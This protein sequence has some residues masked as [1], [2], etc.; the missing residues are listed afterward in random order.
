MHSVAYR[1]QPGSL[2]E[3]CPIFY[4]KAANFGLHTDV[5]V[6]VCQQRL[7]A[8][9][10]LGYG[11]CQAPIVMDGVDANVP[12]A[13]D[14]RMEN[15]SQEFHNRRLHRVPTRNL[16]K[17]EKVSSFVGTVMGPH[18]GC[19]PMTTEGVQWYGPN[20]LWWV[21]MEELEFMLEAYCPPRAVSTEFLGR[22]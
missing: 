14:V 11:E 20:A 12:M 10:N 2:F 8:D 9:E 1:P 15:L 4:V 7:D 6:W 13:T 3:A 16:E 18:D 19:L 21:R 5:A 22:R 17:E